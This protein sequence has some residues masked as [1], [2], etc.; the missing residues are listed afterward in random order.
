MRAQLI[1]HPDFV[2]AAVEGVDVELDLSTAGVAT[3]WYSVFASP[4]ALLVGP[5]VPQRRADEL[6]RT[7]CFELFVREAS[8]PAYLEF[9][10][11]PSTEWAAYRFDDYRHG[12]APFEPPHPPIISSTGIGW[13]E[14]HVTL[15][16]DFVGGRPLQLSAIIEEKDGRKS[17]WA[18]AHPPGEPDFHYPDCFA[19]ELPAAPIPSPRT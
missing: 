7:T 18:L 11:S 6:W 14:L 12:M 3:L 13:F 5:E 4:D 15:P 16:I 1:P 17:Y 8:G 2:P 19:L 10:F 9:N